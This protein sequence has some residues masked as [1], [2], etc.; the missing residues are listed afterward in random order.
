MVFTRYSSEAPK[1][2]N[3]LYVHS[4]RWSVKH[5]CE[6]KD[7]LIAMCKHYAKKWIFQAEDTK[8]NPHYQG[9]IDLKDKDRSST[10]GRKLN[11]EFLGIQFLPASNNGKEALKKYCLKQKSRVD[12]PWSDKPI[13]L[14]QDLPKELTGWQQELFNIIQEDPSFR[15]MI[16][17]YEPMGSTGKTM[18]T[19]YMAYKHDVLPL[20]YG[21][22][23]DILNLVSKFPNKQAY[24]FDLPRTKPSD[25]HTND[26]YSCME[27]IKQGM[28]INTKYDT[29]MVLMKPPHVIVF[30]NWPPDKK[31]LSLDRWKIFT[32]KNN[33]LEKIDA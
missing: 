3:P 25:A 19:K 17:I 24:I 6:N 5:T 9:Y 23:K 2:E 20:S 12:G 1:S 27:S 31:K 30:S 21:N 26:L 14:G 15:S 10:F 4:M 18:F 33:T 11:E 29:S 28:F 22:T 32:N 16:W 8:D 13:Y 7:R